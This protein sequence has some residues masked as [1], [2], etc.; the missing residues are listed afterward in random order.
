MNIQ[1]DFS[2]KEI[3]QQVNLNAAP[4][5]MT[6]MSWLLKLTS[7]SIWEKDKKKGLM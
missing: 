6:D 1:H 4:E 3:N 7:D 5:K 2:E